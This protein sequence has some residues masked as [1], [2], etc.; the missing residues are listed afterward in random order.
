MRT[1]AEVKHWIGAGP[2]LGTKPNQTQNAVAKY[3]A[4]R[5]RLI[6][7]VAERGRAQSDS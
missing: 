2:S 7:A 4:A 5:L 1:A 3:M 6:R